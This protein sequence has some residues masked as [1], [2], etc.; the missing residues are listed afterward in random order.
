MRKAVQLIAIVLLV[1]GGA[2][3]WWTSVPS[4]P[5]PTDL[6][7]L[8]PALRQAITAQHL[9]AQSGNLGEQ[10]K[11]GAVYQAN[12]LCPYAR[13]VYRQVLDQQPELAKA[14]YRLAACIEAE[15]GV[16]AALLPLR[17]AVRWAPDYAPARRQLVAWLLDSGDAPAAAIESA[18]LLRRAPDHPDYQL[19]Q[20]RVEMVAGDLDTA[21]QRLQ[22]VLQQPGPH[23]PYTRHLLASLYRRQGRPEE[24][25]RIADAGSSSRMVWEDAWS[26]EVQAQQV[27]AQRLLQRAV[28]MSSSGRCDEAIGLVRQ[29]SE[30]GRTGDDLASVVAQCQLLQGQIEGA[31]ETLDEALA[32]FP[33]NVTLKLNWVQANLLLPNPSR[34]HPNRLLETLNAA[35]QLEPG[36]AQVWMLRG[37]ILSQAGA[38][39]KA[40]RAWRR[41]W[42]LDQR[43]LAPLLSAAQALITRDQP[44]IAVAWL[45]QSP[46]DHQADPRLRL[47][48][49]LA[50][51]ANGDDEAAA[52][53]LSDADRQSLMR[54]DNQAR[55]LR[56]LDEALEAGQ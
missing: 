40:I 7:T 35:E 53:L 44:A 2:L 32:H 29:L 28:E 5:V 6:D 13:P 10:M 21:L 49:A 18:Q 50:H 20:A 55:L 25:T 11:L 51:V 39:P 9:K 38:T 41:A 14:W 43:N 48:L 46:P 1:G 34:P 37:E 24:A 54:N 52:G 15:E 17:K 33:G 16:I 31:V 30:K 56:Q 19:M 12:G 3:W 45:E 22:S 8:D 27:S 36:N 26:A 47:A 42:Q 4:L 23:Q